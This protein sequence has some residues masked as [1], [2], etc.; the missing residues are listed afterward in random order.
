MANSL[1]KICQLIQEVPSQRAPG[2]I[3]LEVSEDEALKAFAFNLTKLTPNTRYKLRLS[4][5]TVKGEGPESE[6]IFMDTDFAG[7]LGEL[8]KS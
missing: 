2:K 3:R 7:M 8:K 5:A 4:A 1:L 6:P